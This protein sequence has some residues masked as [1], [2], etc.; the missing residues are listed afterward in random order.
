VYYLP[1]IHLKKL[2]RIS[3]EQSI[4]NNRKKLECKARVFHKEDEQHFKNYVNKIFN[5]D[6]KFYHEPIKKKN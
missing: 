3:E 2:F 6:V 5:I 4:E 1:D